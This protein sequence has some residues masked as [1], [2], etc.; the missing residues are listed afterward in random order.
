MANSNQFSQEIQKNYSFEG[1]SLI[2]GAAKL[3]GQTVPGPAVRIP[4]RTLNRHGLVAG[5]TGTGKTKTLQRL[6]ESLSDSSVP[7]LLMD[8]KGDLSGITQ[9]GSDH[10]KIQERVQAIGITWKPA[11]YPAEFLTLSQEKGVRLR[12]TVSEFGPVLF[13]KILELNETQASIVSLI[14]KYADDKALP[15]VDLKDIRKLI[16]FLTNEGKNELKAEYGSISTA[17]TGL[18][19]R[20]IV[21]IEEQGADLFFGEKSFDV[22]DLARLDANGRGVV[23]IL[24]LTDLQNRPKLFSTFMLSLLAEIFQKFPEEGDVEQPKLVIFV[25]EAH[26]IFKEATKTLLGELET[27]IKLIRSKGV[28]VIFCTQSPNDIPQAILAQLGLKVQHALRAFTAV[29]RKAIK[30]VSENYPESAYYKV[31]DLITQLGIGE[32]LVTGLNEKGEPTMLVHTLMAPPQSRMDTITDAEMQN[33]LSASS[34]IQ[35]YNQTMDPES[36]YEILTAKLAQAAQNQPL[37]TRQTTQPVAVPPKP[38]P[39][40]AAQKYVQSLGKSV[41]TSI[42]RNV[43]G[44]ITRSILGSILGSSRRR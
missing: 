20:K 27:V 10:P 1:A 43:T 42:V 44:Q 37:A 8:M 11:G 29:D 17:S 32:A 2:L 36:A 35:K 26:L 6:A 3:D 38:A 14:F 7:V 12:A 40:T 28:G 16:Q 13:S 21:E 39:P 33:T 30:L 41:A 18:I 31:E 25:D 9:P 22:E 19:L 15:L 5:A 24:R 4:L 34:L 23:N